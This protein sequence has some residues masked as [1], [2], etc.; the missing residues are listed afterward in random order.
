MDSWEDVLPSQLEVGDL[1]RV[2]GATWTPHKVTKVEQDKISFCFCGDKTDISNYRRDLL[3]GYKWV[4]VVKE[5][6][7]DPSQQGDREDDI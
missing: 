3:D 4:R 7:Y 1:F 6:Q 5:L 2:K